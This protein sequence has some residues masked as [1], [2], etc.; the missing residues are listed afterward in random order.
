LL[1]DQP[2]LIRYTL[3]GNQHQFSD[4]ISNQTQRHKDVYSRFAP[5]LHRSTS[6]RSISQGFERLCQDFFDGKEVHDVEHY[7]A[8]SPQGSSSD[9][10]L[11]ADHKLEPNPSYQ[12][13]EFEGDWS[14]VLDIVERGNLLDNSPFMTL[15]RDLV[16]NH[17]LEDAARKHSTYHGFRVQFKK[18]VKGAEKNIDLMRRWESGETPFELTSLDD[19]TDRNAEEPSTSL[20]KGVDTTSND[21]TWSDDEPVIEK[22]TSGRKKPAKKGKYREISKKLNGKQ[23]KSRPQEGFTD[24]NSEAADVLEQGSS[25]ENGSDLANFKHCTSVAKFTTEPAINSEAG[26][27]DTA[28][29]DDDGNWNLVQPNSTRK[30]N[31]SRKVLPPGSKG[32]QDSGTSPMHNSQNQSAMG[33][34]S[35]SLNP[36]YSS[37]HPLT[38]F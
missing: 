31:V 1:P 29:F 13:S 22:T 7:E 36:N 30:L 27:P 38:F 35:V 19:S 18:A 28:G 33:S 25:N 37:H 14:K 3:L 24:L 20:S 8:E 12:I 21:V 5:L 6:S 26:K 32:V 4:F 23:S 9:D 17:D 15:L 16:M 2:R 34:Q 11:Q 10:F